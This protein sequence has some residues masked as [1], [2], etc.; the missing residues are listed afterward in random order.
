MASWHLRPPPEVT[1]NDDDSDDESWGE[2]TG[3]ILGV[4]Y[5]PKDQSESENKSWGESRDDDDSN[6]DDSNDDSNDD[7]SHDDGNNDASDDEGTKSDD[8]QNDN[9]KEVEHEDE[10]VRT[11]SSF[12]STD[13]E[14]KY[15]DKEVYDRIDDELYKDMNTSYDEVKDDAHVTLTAVHDTQKTKVSLQSSSIS[16]DFANQFLNLDNV[17]AA[18]NEIISMMNVDVRHEEPTKSSSQPQSTYEATA[19][20]TEFK[21]KKILLDKIQKSQLYRGAKE[22][23]ELYDGLVKSYKLDKDLFESDGKSYPLKEI[24]KTRI[25]I[26]ILQ[27]DKTIGTKSQPKSSSKS[28]KAEDSKF[29]VADTEMS[30]NLG[31]DL[32]N[33]GKQPIKAALKHDCK[34]AQVEKPPLSFDEL[35]STP[36]DFSAYVMNHLKI[37]NLTQDYLVRPVFNLL[38]GT[39]RSHVELEYNIEECYKTITD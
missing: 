24:V 29:E 37:D 13:D 12:E 33:T 3:T 20:L 11:P 7:D 32:G 5:V 16:S 25:K 36:N 15:V 18:D 2:S 28:A 22:H 14:N 6:D 9:D 38:K 35:L 39:C 21:L 26:K 23:E 34:I 1:R 17:L 30:Q 8:D 10:Y 27:L 19:S 4:P 31:S